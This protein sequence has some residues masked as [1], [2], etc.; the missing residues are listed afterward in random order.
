V[1]ALLL[2][3]CFATIRDISVDIEAK[4]HLIEADIPLASGNA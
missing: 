4:A 2:D 3:I 1:E